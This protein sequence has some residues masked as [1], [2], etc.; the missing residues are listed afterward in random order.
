MQSAVAALGHSCKA[1]APA[2]QLGSSRSSLAPQRA[3]PGRR[4]QRRLAVVAAAAPPSAAEV[5]NVRFG[6]QLVLRK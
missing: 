2:T 5:A 1:A 3:I 4:P 6:L